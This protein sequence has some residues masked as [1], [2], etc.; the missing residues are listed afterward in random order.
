MTNEEKQLEEYLKRPVAYRA[1]F[2]KAL[3]SAKLAIL[4]SQFYYWCDKGYDPNGWFYKNRSEIFDETGLSRSEQ[5][6]ARKRGRELGVLEEIKKGTPRRLYFK[7]NKTILLKLITEY[8]AGNLPASRRKSLQQAGRKPACK[9]AENKPAFY[10]ENTTETT[11]ER[12]T[13]NTADA[14]RRHLLNKK[15]FEQG[16]EWINSSQKTIGIELNQ[17]I[18]WSKKNFKESALK[19]LTAFIDHWTED[20]PYSYTEQKRWE[21]EKYF[22]VFA[23]FKGWLKKSPEISKRNDFLRGKYSRFNK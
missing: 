3:G 21:G 16:T 6:T 23:R 22:D 2:A 18:D 8:K 14:K 10:T 5:E 19:E 13:K 15:F 11:T 12:T 1:E 4:L 9:L 7:I 17:V 20:D